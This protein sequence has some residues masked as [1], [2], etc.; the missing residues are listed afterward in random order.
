MTSGE[1]IDIRTYKNSSSCTTDCHLYTT[2]RGNSPGMDIV[3]VINVQSHM[4]FFDEFS[5]IY[6]G[7]H[8]SHSEGSTMY[9]IVDRTVQGITACTGFTQVVLFI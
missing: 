4:P 2:Q 3:N 7:G 6:K 1:P 9:P 8:A 5:Y